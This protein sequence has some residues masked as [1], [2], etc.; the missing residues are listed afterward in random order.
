MPQ[1]ASLLFHGR[2]GKTRSLMCSMRWGGGCV[3][4][5]PHRDIYPAESH[6]PRGLASLKMWSQAKE[7]VWGQLEDRRQET[8][9]P[10]QIPSLI[11]AP[12]APLSQIPL[13]IPPSS[14][15]RC[16]LPAT[17][18]GESCSTPTVGSFGL[19]SRRHLSAPW[20][21]GPMC[22][23]S[24]QP[25]A[26]G[27][28]PRLPHVLIQLHLLSQEPAFSLVWSV[29][30]ARP[31]NQAAKSPFHRPRRFVMAERSV[32]PVRLRE[33]NGMFFSLIPGWTL[34]MGWPAQGP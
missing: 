25:G 23:F 32:S 6:P 28:L 12:L 22:C 2:K 34:R 1:G 11:L 33:P 16:S 10:L 13:H 17:C 7:A 8:A 3:Q 18:R 20:N 15:S 29:P 14:P 5:F 4:V 21:K 27:L 30:G 26:R 19:S 9:S 31:P 24:Q